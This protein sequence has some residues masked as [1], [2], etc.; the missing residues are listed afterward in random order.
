MTQTQR[1]MKR[2]AFIKT[3]MDRRTPQS[4]ALWREAAERL[5]SILA[6]YA[7][8][9][10]G[11]RAHT[12]NS[13]FPAAAIYLSTKE[14]LGQPPPTE[15]SKTRPRSTPPPWGG[16]SRSWCACRAWPGCS[17]GCGIP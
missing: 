4:D 11:V 14:A 1:I 13:I 12:D 2:K 8:L 16:S 7:S 10:G 3:E 15:S 9:S 5:D 6:Q 17:S